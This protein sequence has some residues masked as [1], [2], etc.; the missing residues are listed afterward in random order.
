MIGSVQDVTKAFDGFVT[1]QAPRAP[2]G[3]P[4][5]NADPFLKVLCLPHCQSPKELDCAG[6]W[7]VVDS[8]PHGEIEGIQKPCTPQTNANKPILQD[9]TTALSPP[10]STTECPQ[11]NA[12]HRWL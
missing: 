3:P 8:S 4:M 5:L 7:S 2:L 1:W 12:E 11:L 10:R 9:A 6:V